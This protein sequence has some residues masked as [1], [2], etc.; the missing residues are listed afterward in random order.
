[1]KPVSLFML[2]MASFLVV[3]MGCSDQSDPVAS[4]IDQTVA[5][6]NPTSS[7]GKSDCVMHE[8][9]GSIF[10]KTIPLTGQTDEINV[11]S[12]VRSPRG[13]LVGQIYLR[14]AGPQVVFEGYAIDLKVVQNKA[15]IC[16]TITKGTWALG[17]PPT[18][19]KGSLVCLVAI[20]HGSHDEVSL[21]M[22]TDGTEIVPMTKQGVIDMSPDEYVKWAMDFFGVTYTQL[23]PPLTRGL[24]V[25]K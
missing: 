1:M 16:Y 12:A 22:V 10:W 20:D 5:S 25:V 24:V 15:K 13:K 21:C 14:D 11:F 23:F 19:I 8:V 6:E 2:L 9:M 4:P 3:L 17:S 18:D 7:L